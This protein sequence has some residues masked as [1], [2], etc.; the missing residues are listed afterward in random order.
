MNLAWRPDH[1]GEGDAIAGLGIAL[2]GV[3]KSFGDVQVLSGL[4]L[5]I[6]P[7]QFVAV[8]GR[9]GSGKST[10]L[11]LVAGLERAGGGRVTIGQKPVSGLDPAVRLLFQE[12]RLV[13]WQKVVENVGIARG[14]NWREGALGALR[15]VGL[16]GRENDWPSVLSGGQ[17]QRVARAR[18]SARDPASRRAFRR[19]RRAHAHRDAQ[20]ARRHLARPPV[21]HDAD[22]A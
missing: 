7:G 13:P 8:V 19:A 12:A 1:A 2:S 10:L 20:A 4:D 3:S 6:P 16:D 15:D 21:H 18:Q 17:R 5:H 22:H 14:P 11:R 9:S